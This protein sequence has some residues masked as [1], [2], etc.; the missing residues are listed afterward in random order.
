MKRSLLIMSAIILTGCSARAVL[1][2][3]HVDYDPTQEAR[4]RVYNVNGNATSR[5]FNETSCK[6]I[7]EDPKKGPSKNPFSRDN[8]HN[9]LPKHTLKN[10][11]IGMPLTEVSAEALNRDSFTDAVYFTEQVVTANK[12]VVIKGSQ[13]DSYTCQIMGEF[14]PQA[15]K[16]Y[17]ISYSAKIDLPIS[18]PAVLPG[19]NIAVGSDV[20]GHCK[21]RIYELD[22]LTGAQNDKVKAKI[23]KEVSYKRCP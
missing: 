14:T 1:V 7:A 8:M 3:K 22:T 10:I 17:E 9:R 11:S 20:V 16:D 23:G 19:T 2:Q 4:I 15:G 21:M 12:P 6:D 18:V 13:Y 5:A